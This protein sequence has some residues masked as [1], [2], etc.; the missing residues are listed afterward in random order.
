M[1]VVNLPDMLNTRTETATR[2]Y[3]EGESIIIEAE[4]ENTQNY[5]ERDNHVFAEAT[6]EEQVLWGNFGFLFSGVE[7]EMLPNNYIKLIFEFSPARN[8]GPITLQQHRNNERSRE[9]CLDD[10]SFFFE[11]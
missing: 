11:Q 5:T 7:L 6:S 8:Y 1:T 4:V 3:F 9:I 10:F 2:Y